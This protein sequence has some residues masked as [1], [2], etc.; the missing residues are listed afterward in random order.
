MNSL[1]ILADKFFH[2]FYQKDWPGENEPT[3]DKLSISEAYEVQDCVAQKRMK[4][5]CNSECF[6]F[7]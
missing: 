7:M 2:A 4:D 3:L 5:F 1:E 6:L